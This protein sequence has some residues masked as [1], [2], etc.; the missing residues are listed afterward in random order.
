[1]GSHHY[2][3]L[4][5]GGHSSRALVFNTLGEL[6]AQSSIPVETHQPQ[7]GWVEQDACEL[8]TSLQLAAVQVVHQL[9]QTAK[10]NLVAAALVTQRSSLVCWDRRNGKSLYPVISWQDKRAAE[11]LKHQ[12]IDPDWIR[13]R[14]GLTLNPHYGASKIRWCLDHLQ[15][16]Q[17]AFRGGHL[18]CGPLAS[19]LVSRLTNTDHFLVD[20]ANASRT[21]LWNIET[22]DW[23]DELLAC[24][25]ITKAILP[26]LVAT[27]AKYGDLEIEGHRVP[28]RLLNG[29]Q[30]VALFA[31]GALS[32]DTAYINAGTGAFISAPWSNSSPSPE[33][34][35][36][37][38]IHQGDESYFVVEGTV[39]GAASA[40]DWVQTQY[41]LETIDQLDVWAQQQQEVP[42]F[43]NG[44]A[45]LGSPYWCD[46]SSEFIGEGTPEQKMVAALESIVFLLETN[47]LLMEG[48]G[49]K[50]NKIQISGGLSKL[51]SFCQKMAD[52][53][54]I[55]VFRPEQIE[56][57][58]RGA[59]YWL[60]GRPSNWQ[61]L[62]TEAFYP[63]SSQAK[64]IRA[65]FR[66]WREALQTRLK[67]LSV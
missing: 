30:S 33:S 66:C 44:V 46:L 23:D 42:L 16:V 60:A 32:S 10:N 48:Q 64:D 2:L 47:L 59:A 21:L 35:L 50:A 3:I 58:A 15:S 54:G 37:S 22:K 17:E 11:W 55:P 13:Q 28:L 9:N 25:G 20:P 52:L 1:M 61:N 67:N 34:L 62:N 49:F 4:D 45:G 5:Q 36:K 18:A 19:Y 8:V 56:A 53:S 12:G 24:F 57:T 31:T 63:P 38:L 51:N 41:G 26:T 39:N 40:L 7:A 43:M 27:Q 65:R 6:V 29:D 14:T